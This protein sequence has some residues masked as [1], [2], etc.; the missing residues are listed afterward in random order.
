LASSVQNRLVTRAARFRGVWLQSGAVSFVLA[1]VTFRFLK[2]WL[3]LVIWM[4][5]IFS[6]STGA[7]RPQN[8][9]RFLRPFLQIFK[10]DLTNE[11]FEKIHFVIRKTGHFTEYAILGVLLWRA[12][13]TEQRFRILI[14]AAQFAAVL[15][16]CAFYAST[17]EFHQRF[18]SDREASVHDVVLDTCGA[19]FGL[20][21]YGVTI[22]KKRT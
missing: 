12:L 6:A 7:G 17:D 21:V 11:Q 19:A 3:P 8:T 4:L 1:V 5:V 15:F 2:Y 16:L 10:P 13:R 14:P 9:S 18:V 20:A 22:R